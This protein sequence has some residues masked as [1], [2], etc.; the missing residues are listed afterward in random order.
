MYD[1]SIEWLIY[2]PPK[3]VSFGH[4]SRIRD[5][6]KAWPATK[7]FLDAFTCYEIGH[8]RSL[9]CLIADEL[10]DPTVLQQHAETARRLFGPET[11]APDSRHWDLPKMLLGSAIELALDDDKFPK[12]PHGPTSL[13]FHYRFL[14][15]AFC[16]S[17]PGQGLPEGFDGSRSCISNFGII[18][19]GQRVFLQPTFVFPGS[20]QSPEVLSF[21]TKL[22]ERAP[23]RF[24]DQYFKRSLPAVKKHPYRR[25][26]MYNLKKGW[27]GQ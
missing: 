3:S 1:E 20:W 12:L 22:E 27:R 16:E 6:R 26:R 13:A 14:W 24:R 7:A 15:T 11:R 2:H 17:S 21:L 23:F 5:A 4:Q 8:H 25:G 9:T 19:G 18:L 10:L